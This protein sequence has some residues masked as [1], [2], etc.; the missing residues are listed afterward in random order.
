[1][2]RAGAIVVG[3]SVDGRIVVVRACDVGDVEV[4]D[5]VRNA[6]SAN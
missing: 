4:V 3:M 1:M 2:G 5:D 6:C